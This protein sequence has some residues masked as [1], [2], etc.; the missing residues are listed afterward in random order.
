MIKLISGLRGMSISALALAGAVLASSATLSVAGGGEKSPHIERQKWTFS[1]FFG[2][3]DQAQLQ[4][5][6]HVYKEVCSSCHGLK[7]LSYRNLWEHGGPAFTED[8]VKA[9]AAEVE[10]TY[11]KDGEEATRK[12][13]PS[14]RFVTPPAAGDTA[15]PDL[16]VMAKARNTHSDSPWYLEPVD[17]AKDIA[18][19][20]QEGG[21]DY[22]YALLTGYKDAPA[23]VKVPD[24]MAYNPYFPGHK[25][26]MTKPLS[27]D[28]VEYTDG[29]PK[30]VDQYAKDVS[31]FLMWTADPKLQERKQMGFRVLIYLFVLAL[32]LYLAKKRLWSRIK[33]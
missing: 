23:G 17:W 20:Y 14:D 12:A 26:G 18:T 13:I 22:I 32:L 24:G 8:Q 25:I 19:G 7:L 9:L 6:Y 27:D 11:M 21:P 5:G 31:A 28:Q 15:P 29:S 2:Y 33:H 4:R 30:T 1:G 3:Y 10:I 16:S